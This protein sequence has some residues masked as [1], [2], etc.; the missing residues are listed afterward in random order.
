MHLAL[1]L[2]SLLGQVP[3]DILGRVPLLAH[4]VP[5]RLDMSPDLVPLNDDLSL[6]IDGF[7]DADPVGIVPPL[8]EE[9]PHARRQ[10]VSEHPRKVLLLEVLLVRPKSQRQ[11]G[12]ALALL[13]QS[14][15]DFEGGLHRMLTTLTVTLFEG[16]AE[17]EQLGETVG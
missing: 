3:L 13:K 1:L 15:Q 4:E 2:L 12:L 5:E 7:R 11:E 17:V 10:H 8:A 9:V 6:S 16:L 14:A